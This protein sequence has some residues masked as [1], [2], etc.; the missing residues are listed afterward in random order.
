MKLISKLPQVIYSS[1]TQYS[2][3][4]RVVDFG[5]I[6]RLLV[7]GLVQSISLNEVNLE[8]KVW[9]RLAQPPFDLPE[10]P[11]VLMLGLGGGT[12][13]HIINKTLSPSLIRVV[14]NDPQIIEI[15]K[16][17]F[18]L[19]KIDNLEVVNQ[20]AFKYLET[21][22]E[23]FNYV[24]IDLYAGKDFPKEGSEISFY[25]NIQ[26]VLGKSGGFVVNRIFAEDE[27]N[28]RG[29][30]FNL[31]KQIFPQVSEQVIPG[32]N[33]FKNYLYFARAS[34]ESTGA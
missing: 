1:F 12:T 5:S 16:N 4:I 19:E 31:L 20:D 27:K 15:A 34:K 25:Q 13:A 10:N 11:K 24:I 17:Y 8:G 32:T 30:Y 26:K 2:G 22:G 14:E 7:G 33:H 3:E 29:D 6:R 23:K 28:S 18:D 21:L 9:G